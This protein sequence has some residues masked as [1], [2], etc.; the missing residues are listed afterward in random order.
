MSA[1]ASLEV[2]LDALAE[3]QARRLA[4]TFLPAPEAIEA[5]PR[6]WSPRR[7][8]ATFLV[9]LG[10][11][12]LPIAWLTVQLWAHTSAVQGAAAEATS[13]ASALWLLLALPVACN[14]AGILAFRRGSAGGG[15]QGGLLPIGQLVCFRIVT[16]GTNVEALRKTV[17]ALR[18]E[19]ARLPLFPSVIEVVTDTSVEL[20]RSGDLRQICVPSDYRTPNGTRFKA[21]ALHY[22][23]EASP[24]PGDAWIFHLDEET[25]VTSSVLRGIATAITEEERA[26]SLRIGQGAVLYHRDLAEHPLLTLADSIRTGDDLGRFRLQHFTKRPLWGLHG[27]F[28][29]V[30]CDVEREVGF[31]F[32]PE[33]SVTE[34]AWWALVEMAH[35]RRTRWVD[36]YCLEQATRSMKDFVK[37]RRRWFVGLM[38]VCRQSPVPLRGRLP[39]LA[40]VLLWGTSWIGWWGVIAAVLVTRAR[41]P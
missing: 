28:I 16:R 23:L 35:G 31:D 32:G 4:D 36:G 30:R 17:Q 41:L 22:A 21:R 33:G 19:I 6:E 14:C 12:A 3:T 39:L 20:P 11:V 2:A 10:L 40:S 5:S 9:L 38:L 7:V 24:L 15:G 37:Q 26:G 25:H 27:S 18:H 34:D 29:L 13:V 8:R 1:A